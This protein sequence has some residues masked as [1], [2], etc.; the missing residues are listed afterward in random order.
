MADVRQVILC[1]FGGQGIVLAGTLL[2]HAAFHDGKWVSG[3]SSYGPAARG[4]EC[5]SEVVVSGSPVVYPH[6]I[7]A[8]I[9]LAMSQ[10]GYDKYI[11]KAKAE[12]EVALVLYDSKFVSPYQAPVGRQVEI[13]ATETAEQRLG[14]VMGANII[15]LGAVVEAGKVVSRDSLLEAIEKHVPERFRELNMK[16]A[17]LGFEL[18]AG[19]S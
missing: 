4:G 2:G 6:A 3:T 5:A 8:D 1:G 13:A 10:Q 11:G 17:E 15:A 19:R 16:A 14:S 9:L 12:A 7:E 18:A